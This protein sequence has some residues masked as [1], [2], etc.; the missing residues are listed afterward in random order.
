METLPIVPFGKYKHQPVT[1]LIGDKTYLEW[2]KKQSGI[3]EKYP[4][5]Y[6]ICV[7]QI[8]PSNTDSK[9]PEHNK[10]QNLFL[11]N[12]NIKQFIKYIYKIPKSLVLSDS[13]CVFEGDF[14][15]DVVIWDGYSLCDSANCGGLVKFLQHKNE[16]E[17]KKR[18]KKIDNE[19]QKEC[20]R[21]AILGRKFQCWRDQATDSATPDEKGRYKKQTWNMG[22]ILNEL[23]PKSYFFYE[24]GYE[25]EGVRLVRGYLR[26]ESGVAKDIRKELENKYKWSK[27]KGKFKKHSK[28][29]LC[30]IFVEVKPTLGDDYPCVLRKM[31]TQKKLMACAF[32]RPRA[33][34]MHPFY[35]VTVLLV[36][37][38]NSENTSKEMLIDIFKQS[39]IKVVFFNEIFDNKLFNS[40]QK[41][42]KQIANTDFNHQMVLLKNENI[43]LLERLKEAEQKIHKLE[44]ENDIL[45][46][47]K[48]NVKKITSFF[49]R[50]S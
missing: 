24:K 19:L 40:T 33:K 25:Q 28:K 45:K 8:L 7:N 44:V 4:I 11:D 26:E 34:A 10:L 43:S 2:V 46:K 42:I 27:Y 48:K 47:S 50:K 5:I 13:K 12:E 6:N 30:P 41:N 35:G 21:L 14:N 39:N 16:I 18:N 20:D 15:W 17:R 29:S 38:F 49:G 9:T 32:N 22:S 1:N 36:K 37:D 23:Y 3:K 31:K